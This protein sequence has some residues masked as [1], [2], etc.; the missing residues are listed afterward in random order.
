LKR[1]YGDFSKTNFGKVSKISE[2]DSGLPEL[3]KKRK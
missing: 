2:F 3:K 1:K